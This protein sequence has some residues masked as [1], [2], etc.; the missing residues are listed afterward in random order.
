MHFAWSCNNSWWENRCQI[1]LDEYRVLYLIMIM[2]VPGNIDYQRIM[3]THG[4][5]S[6]KEE[7]VMCFKSMFCKHLNEWNSIDYQ[8]TNFKKWNYIIIVIVGYLEIWIIKRILNTI[9]EIKNNW[10]LFCFTFKMYIVIYI[11]SYH[12]M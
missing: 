12:I 11:A 6:V 7:S 8:F 1:I 5:G 2:K 9:W 4:T 10:I 3:M